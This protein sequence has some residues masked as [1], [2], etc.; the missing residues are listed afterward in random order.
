MCDASVIMGAVGIG[1]SVG[2]AI[3][4]AVQQHDA[5]E[6]AAKVAQRNKLAAER[7]ASDAIARGEVQAG[8]IRTRASQMI[9]EQRAGF[10][11]M[12]IDASTGSAAEIQGMTRVLSEYDAR[13]TENNAAREAWGYRVEGK[14]FSAQAAASSAAGDNQALATILGGAGGAMQNTAQMYASYQRA[15]D[16]KKGGV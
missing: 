4:G 5:A 1:T 12:G 3:Y 13:L 6:E 14:N 10:A 2:G 7:A 15:Q 8:Q 9:G 11:A 16:L